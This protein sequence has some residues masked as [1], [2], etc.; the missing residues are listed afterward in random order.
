VFV[1]RTPRPVPFLRDGGTAAFPA[2]SSRNSV[3]ALSGHPDLADGVVLV[4]VTAHELN[5]LFGDGELPRRPCWHSSEAKLT[6]RRAFAC[7]PGSI[8]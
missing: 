2:S 1:F 3:A 5:T 7:S 8:S 4:Y 6:R